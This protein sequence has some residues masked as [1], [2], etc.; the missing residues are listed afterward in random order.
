MSD[1]DALQKLKI[2]VAVYIRWCI[3]RTTSPSVYGAGRHYEWGWGARVRTALGVTIER[4]DTN[5][6]YFFIFFL[7]H[8]AC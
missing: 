3:W 6:I 5:G 4:G 2:M 7:H 1:L 8:D